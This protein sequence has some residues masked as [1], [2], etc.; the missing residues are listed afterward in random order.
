MK[1]MKRYIRGRHLTKKEA[2]R[3]KKII[4]QVKKEFPPVFRCPN[5]AKI[6]DNPFQV[7]NCMITTTT[8]RK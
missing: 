5:C 7:H 1:S 8:E 2:A 3:N 6:L 4:E